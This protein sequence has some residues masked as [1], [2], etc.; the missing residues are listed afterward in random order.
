MVYGLWFSVFSLFSD[1]CIAVHV[2]FSHRITYQLDRLYS[3]VPTPGSARGYWN[4]TPLELLI[5][6]SSFLTIVR[7]ASFI[8]PN[9]Q[10]PVPFSLTSHYS[11]SLRL[12]VTPSLP[13]PTKPF[14]RSRSLFVFSLTTHFSLLITF[15]IRQTNLPPLIPALSGQ[16]KIILLKV[17][18][19]QSHP[20]S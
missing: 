17:S 6:S 15:F 2:M 8:I 1:R 7:Q 10:Q 18:S 12:S 9:T 4:S 5:P 16:T 13:C 14:G 11:Y 20:L 19:S 3:C